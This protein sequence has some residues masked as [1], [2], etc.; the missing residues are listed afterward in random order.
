[1]RNLALVLLIALPLFGFEVR[2]EHHA[3]AVSVEQGIFSIL[4][5]DV[6]TGRVLVS[7]HLMRE[8]KFDA[9]DR[10]LRVAVREEQGKLSAELDVEKDGV[11]VDMLRA[12]WLTTARPVTR[13]GDG[14]FRVGGDVRA[15]VVISRVP[16]RYTA[17]AKANRIAGIVI[18]ELVIDRE[19]NVADAKVLKPLPFGLDETALVAAKQWKFQPGTINGEPVDVIFNITINFRPSEDE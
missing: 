18:M 6:K 19:G 14:P 16:P 1:M 12:T 9:D 13:T 5:T 17:E 2:S 4:V 10:Q 8:L 7:E 3:L 15:P 11:I